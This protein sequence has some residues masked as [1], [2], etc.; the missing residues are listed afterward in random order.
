MLA[1]LAFPLVVYRPLVERTQAWA[2]II[3]RCS[4]V[5]LNHFISGLMDTGV[6]TMEPAADSGQDSG[7][8]SC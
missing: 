4:P 6:G 7:F 8:S 1:V 3:P 5:V 2:L